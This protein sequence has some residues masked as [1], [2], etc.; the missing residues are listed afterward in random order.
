M[1]SA[2]QPRRPVSGAPLVPDGSAPVAANHRRTHAPVIPADLGRTRAPS[3]TSWPAVAPGA[4][5][6]F[7]RLLAELA[8]RMIRSPPST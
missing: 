8:L 2:A 1:G 6:A 4:Q 3:A 5:A 7:M